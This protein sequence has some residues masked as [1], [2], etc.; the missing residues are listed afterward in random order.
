VRGRPR[1][2]LIAPTPV[3]DGGPDIAEDLVRVAILDQFLQ[4]GG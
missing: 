1:P 3:D 2:T 4:R